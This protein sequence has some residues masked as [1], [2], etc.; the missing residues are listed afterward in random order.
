MES[1]PFNRLEWQEVRDLSHCIVNATLVNDVVL[2]A[3]LFQDLTVLL[4]R[5][6]ERYGE[7]PILLETAADFCDDPSL[8]LDLYRRAIRLAEAH[9]LP[10]LTIRL[11][12][13]SVLLQDFH[14]QT[15]AA[16]ELMACE[17]E[18]ETAEDKIQ[19]SEWCGLMRQCG[20][21]RKREHHE[22]H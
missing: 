18:V 6:R 2:Q 20:E 21:E 16:R 1:S 13:A 10:T 7:H 9:D 14:D 8:Q 22:R 4:E 5:L 11:S 3:A 12:L 15:E 17:S 19:E